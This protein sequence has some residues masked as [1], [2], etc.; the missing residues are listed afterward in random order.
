[1]KRKLG[2]A[3]GSSDTGDGRWKKEFGELMGVENADDR[4]R[5]V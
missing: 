1:M 4:E 2:E 3:I 5:Q